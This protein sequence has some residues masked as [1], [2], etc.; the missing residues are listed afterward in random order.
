VRLISCNP[1][2]ISLKTLIIANGNVETYILFRLNRVTNFL[3]FFVIYLQVLLEIMCLFGLNCLVCLCYEFV[4]KSRGVQNNRLYVKSTTISKSKT[5]KS[6][7]LKMK[8]TNV[9]IC[10]N[11][12][13]KSV[14]I[15]SFRKICMNIHNKNQQN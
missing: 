13:N 2:K 9:L 10:M 15:F 8:S 5:K 14:T 4:V 6:V 3:V 7:N 1:F 12:H 11:I